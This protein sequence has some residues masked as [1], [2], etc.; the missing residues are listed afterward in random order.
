MMSRLGLRRLVFCFA[1]VLLCVLAGCSRRVPP[2]VPAPNNI[3]KPTP[4]RDVAV[5]YHSASGY[6][7]VATQLRKLLPPE[8]YR[9]TVVDVQAEG[10]QTR[11]D[12]LRRKPNIFT[13]AIGL[14]AARLAR[15]ELKGPLLFAE[16]FNYQELLVKGRPI[17]GVAP[18]PRLDL[19][20]QDW[21]K[22][23]PNVR[24]LGIIVSQSHPELIAQAERAAKSAAVTITHEI[25]GSDRETLYL[26]KRLAPQIDGL[27]LVPDDQILSPG[28]LH[29]LLDYA[30]AHGVRVCVLSD[31]L[32]DWGALMSARP[33]PTDTAR[34][35]LR[36]LEKMM[37]GGASVV[38]LLTPTSEL[39]VRL[40]TQVAGRFGLSSLR[41]SWVVRRER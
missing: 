21:K 17:R 23:D 34:T 11:L 10:S 38:P 40:N 8:T 5:L 41:S 26:F 37:T 2:P 15:D 39:V 13:V 3:P 22:R 24:R 19:Q 25:S 28:V 33:T 36:V 20:V 35:L 6:A 16:V 30:V 31:A 27:W 9:V 7:D 29:D 12:S 18:V 32:L 4:L 14:P 1:T